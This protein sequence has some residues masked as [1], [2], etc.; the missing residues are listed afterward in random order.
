MHWGTWGVPGIEETP[1]LASHLTANVKSRHLRV[2]DKF[3]KLF[4]VPPGAEGVLQLV[5]RA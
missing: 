1:G 4:Q 5:D 2:R 3:H